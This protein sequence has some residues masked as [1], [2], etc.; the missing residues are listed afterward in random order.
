MPPFAVCSPAV[1]EEVIEVAGLDPPRGSAASRNVLPPLPPL[2]D[3][4]RTPGSRA[5]RQGGP[6]FVTVGR[7]E[8][9]GTCRC[10]SRP[11]TSIAEPLLDA[12]L[13][14]AGDDWRERCCAPDA[15]GLRAG[16]TSPAG[17]ATWPRRPISRP[18]TPSSWPPTRKASA[19]VLSEAM[20]E[21]C[22]WDQHRR[23]GRRRALR[24]R[25]WPRRAAGADRRCRG[26]ARGDRPRWPSRDASPLCRAR[27]RRRLRAA[28]GRRRAA[29]ADGEIAAARR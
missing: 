3:G 20:H 8:P 15:R 12:R 4:C 7:L 19:E 14:I 25:R 21:G 10:C 22:R 18:P 23:R 29:A 27:Q 16:R 5:G 28:A 26:A 9:V 2:A 24:A 17:S 13:L 1:R 6:V 11:S